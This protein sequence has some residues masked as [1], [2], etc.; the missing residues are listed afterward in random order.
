MKKIILGAILENKEI[1]RNIYRLKLESREAS[2]NVKPGQFIN[3]YLK[4]KSILLPRPISICKV[5]GNNLILV[6]KALGKGTKELSAYR[7]GDSIKISSSLGNGFKMDHLINFIES[8]PISSSGNHKRE[9][10]IALV[11]GGVGVPPLV[12]LA[13]AIMERIDGRDNNTCAGT[14][15]QASKNKLIAIVGFGEEPFLI[16]ELEKI[17]H[18]VYLATD[19]GKV[20]FHGSVMGLLENKNIEA[21]YYL[22]CG[23]RPMLKNLWSYCDRKAVHLQVSM[24]ERMGCGYGAC[25]GCTCKTKR[26]AE[27]QM[28]I[29]S[30]KVCKDGPVFMGSEVVWDEI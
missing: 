27:G 9:G 10:V 15:G 26:Q 5:E 29:V 24:E 8:S 4:D 12:G 28:E 23:P 25:V 16:E 3:I 7:P 30:Q 20:G 1:A 17:C 18:E 13:E 11:G 14:K 22:A 19:N 6:Y 21:D 2:I